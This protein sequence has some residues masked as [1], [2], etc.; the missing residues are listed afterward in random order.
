[1]IEMIRITTNFRLT[2]ALSAS[3]G[4]ILRAMSNV[5]KPV[6]G[7]DQYYPLNDPAIGSV[8]PEVS[9]VSIA[10]PLAL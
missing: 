8:L 1:M 9:G 5:S 6:P 10:M 4:R 2:S 7:A 3:H